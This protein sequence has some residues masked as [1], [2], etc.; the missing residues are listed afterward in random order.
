MFLKYK[1]DDQ[2]QLIGPI[3]Q[4]ESMSSANVYIFTLRF[5][6]PLSHV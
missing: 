1:Y 6:E 4:I 2:L 3:L 5:R